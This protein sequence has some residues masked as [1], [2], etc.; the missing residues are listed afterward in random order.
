VRYVLL[1]YADESLLPGFMTADVIGGFEALGRE[2]ATR[3]RLVTMGGLASITSATTVRVRDGEV[4]VSDGPFAETREQLGGFS[5]AGFDSL[6][7]ACAHALRVPTATIGAVEIR[8]IME[9]A[10]AG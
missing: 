1:V 10:G 6:D 2:L 4:L 8:P 5:V 7:D 9:I 3:G